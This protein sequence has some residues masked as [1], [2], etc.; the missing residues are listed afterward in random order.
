MFKVFIP[1]MG[2]D[3]DR[4]GGYRHGLHLPLRLAGGRIRFNECKNPY[5]SRGQLE[6]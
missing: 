3:G 4:V 1:F 5:P 6:P 2:L